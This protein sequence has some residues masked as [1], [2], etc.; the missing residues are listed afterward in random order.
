MPL[1]PWGFLVGRLADDPGFTARGGSW[2]IGMRQGRR[3]TSR[4]NRMRQGHNFYESEGRLVVTMNTFHTY[5]TN[6]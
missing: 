2:G 4:G 3:D 6:V 1:L 5:A